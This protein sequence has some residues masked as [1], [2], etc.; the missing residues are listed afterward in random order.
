MI[1]AILTIVF[2]LLVALWLRAELRRPH[3]SVARQWPWLAAAAA[4]QLLAGWLAVAYG[5]MGTGNV[6]LHS[7]GGGSVGVMLFFYLLRTFGFQLGWR[8]Q[9]AALFCFVCTLGVLNEL[10][11]MAMELAGVG[12]FSFDSRD[13]WRDFVSNT[14]G[15]VVTWIVVRIGLAAAKSR[16]Q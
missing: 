9:L 13:T 15:A 16:I 12:I 11:E 3:I 1:Y 7:V 4:L 8:L 6:L 5:E 2:A 14:S 10:G